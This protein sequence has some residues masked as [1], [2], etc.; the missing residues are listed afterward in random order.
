YPS[1][2]SALQNYAQLRGELGPEFMRKYSALVTGVAIAKGIGG[3]VRDDD[4]LDNK[5]AGEDNDDKDLDDQP[6]L[7]ADR[8]VAGAIA[9]FLKEKKFTA[10]EVYQ[11]DTKQQQ[12]V[13]YLKSRK[14]GPKLVKQAEQSKHLVGLLKEAMVRLGQRPASRE[15]LPDE[16]TWLRWITSNYE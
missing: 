16:V 6:S 12:L 9:D 7:P 11:D 8:D 2:A 10:L 4:P 13:A 5:K 3:V 14:L 15:A 1:D